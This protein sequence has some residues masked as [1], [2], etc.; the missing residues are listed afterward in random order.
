MR[1]RRTKRRRRRRT[2][3]QPPSLMC[4]APPSRCCC[5]EVWCVHVV[6]QQLL[7]RPA[8]VGHCVVWPWQQPAASVDQDRCQ[9]VCQ[10]VACG[11]RDMR[12]A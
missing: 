2:S 11:A 4:D 12:H 6:A 8:A 5:C 7:P 3:K 9:D 10:C 1:T